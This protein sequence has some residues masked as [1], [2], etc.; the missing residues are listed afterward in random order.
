MRIN[1]D[2]KATT[3]LKDVNLTNMLKLVEKRKPLRR[4][5]FGDSNR[6]SNLS[7]IYE[8]RDGSEN[9]VKEPEPE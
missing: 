8:E 6:K 3:T 9:L 5:R 7:T 1:D 2:L 4:Y